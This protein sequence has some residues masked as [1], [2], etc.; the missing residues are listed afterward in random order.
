[1]DYTAKPFSG[2]NTGADFWRDNAIS[3]GIDEAVIICRNY[4]DLNLKREHPDDERQFCREIFVAMYEATANKIVPNRIVYP[5][6][7]ETSNNRM[8]TSYFHKN[9]DFNQACVCA[10][11]TAINASCYKTNYYN[12]ELAAMS[13]INGHGFERVNAV[14]A[15]HIQKHENDG[16]YSSANKKWAK[17]FML[18]DNACVFLR[19]HAILVEGFTTYARKL[20]TDMNADRFVLMGNEEH[21]EDNQGFTITR[22]IMIDANQG[23]VI[24]H[25]PNAVSPFV[26]WQFYIR[27]GERHYNWGI[28]GDEQ[29]AIDSYNARLFV[30]FN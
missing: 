27:D 25:N 7:F 30:A 26:C 17:G 15:H 14:L 20:Y 23:Y 18:P 5:Y 2:Y 8:E 21:G 24:A 19:S 1:M 9:R 28:Y 10:I 29:V 13:V 4:I 12:L 11:D 6:D 3:Y 16:R 22:S